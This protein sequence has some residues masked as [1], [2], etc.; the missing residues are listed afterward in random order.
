MG[1]IREADLALPEYLLPA[2]RQRDMQE[3]RARR[4]RLD[5]AAL[6]ALG[7]LPEKNR[8]AL[9]LYYLGGY[10][11]DEVAAFLGTSGQAVKMRLHR[12]RKQL[13]KEALKMVETTLGKKELGPDFNDR[14]NRPWWT[15]WAPGSTWTIP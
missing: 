11:L 9:T 1:Q 2:D 13:R 15:T 6:S 4:D 14:I 8:Q 5:A 12:A 10:T 7:R 3:Q